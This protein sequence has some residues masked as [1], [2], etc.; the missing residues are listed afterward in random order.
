LIN[1]CTSRLKSLSNP[2]FPA[3]ASNP[4]REVDA[5]KITELLITELDHEAIGSRKALEH[6]PE[7]KNDWKPHDKSMPLGRLATIVATTP[8]WIEMVMNMDE[9]DINP[10]GGSKFNPQP[11]KTRRDLLQQFEA[12][13][14]KGKEILQKTTDDHLFN[15]KWRML[16]AGKLM[17]EQSRYEAIREGVINHMAH[18][19]GQLTVYLRLNGET[20]P[21]IYG[22]SA[23][24][25]K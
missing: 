16:S 21:A 18:H 3:A 19:R 5:M 15:T 20:V 8:A 2:A 12:S 25:G 13:L 7:G 11:W 23:D 17:M 22:P 10:P 14:Q 1:L 24:E 6:V 9:M 4:E